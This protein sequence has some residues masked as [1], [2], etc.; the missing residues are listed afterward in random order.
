MARQPTVLCTRPSSMV[1]AVSR[2]SQPIQPAGVHGWSQW[3]DHG[4][5]RS[6]PSTGRDCSGTSSLRPHREI[7]CWYR[8]LIAL[9][10]NYRSLR[11][12][13]LRGVPVAIDEDRRCLAFRR[14]TV[15]I[16]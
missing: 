7:F 3:V 2:P 5:K 4:R 10:Q 9:R 6:I 15:L 1:R 13:K 14:G 16:V 11:D 12:G 8:A